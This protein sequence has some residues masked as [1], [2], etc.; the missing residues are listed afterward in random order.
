[1]KNWN[2]VGIIKAAV[3]LLVALFNMFMPIKGFS[4]NALV[5]SIVVFVFGCLTPPILTRINASTLHWEIKKPNWNEN[6]LNL[7]QP[8]NFFQFA[9]YFFIIAGV[10]A[11]IGTGI[12]FKELNNLGLISV[13]LG[14]GILIG[15]FFTWKRTQ[16]KE[17]TEE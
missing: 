13:V 12:K 5:M 7:K 6:P 8:L 14:I 3:L 15:V 11:T 16:K 2:T 9:A 4:H 10:S 1:M 17:E